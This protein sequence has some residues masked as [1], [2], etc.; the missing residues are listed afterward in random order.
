MGTAGMKEIRQR[1]HSVE[2]TMQITKA[3]ELVASSKLRRAKERAE[4]ARPYFTILYETMARIATETTGFRSVYTNQRPVKKS[5]FV[6]IA[7]DR[8]LAGGYNSNVLNLALEQMEEKPAVVFPIGKK[9]IEFFQKRGYEMPKRYSGIAETVDLKEIRE[10]AAEL[11]SLYRSKRI[12]EI[13]LVYTN[14]VSPLTQ[15]PAALKLLPLNFGKQEKS[16]GSLILYEPSPDAVFS[17]IIPEYLAG[18]LYG[19][20]VESFASEQGARRN[21]MNAASDNA[22]EMIEALNL[23]Y[24]R[25]RQSSIT[26]EITEIVAGAGALR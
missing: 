26:Q 7:G 15:S 21:A 10:I 22:Q 3:M 17:Q 11:L 18:V 14:F 16:A 9:A 20:L 1:I 12:D 6:V 13:T 8:G 23:D 4:R 5:A 24:N 2:N 25:A 19:A